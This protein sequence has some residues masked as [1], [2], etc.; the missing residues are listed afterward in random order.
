MVSEQIENGKWCIKT[1]TGGLAT[2]ADG[3]PFCFDTKEAADAFSDHHLDIDWAEE[4]ASEA[5][6]DEEQWNG[7]VFDV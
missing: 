7:A 5:L 2:G 4:M 3:E 6:D 1:R